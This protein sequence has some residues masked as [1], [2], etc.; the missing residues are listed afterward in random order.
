MRGD[1]LPISQGAQLGILLST[2]CHRLRHHRRVERPAATHRLRIGR[3]ALLES[4][5]DG[6]LTLM[7][8]VGR[9]V[10]VEILDRLDVVVADQRMTR[11]RL[12]T[13]LSDRIHVS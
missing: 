10:L 2:D 13:H 9:T 11:H 1:R 12:L 5:L 4:L 7:C 6:D 3:I 8:P